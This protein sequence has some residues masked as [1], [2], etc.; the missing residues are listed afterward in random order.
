MLK[1]CKPDTDTVLAGCMILHHYNTAQTGSAPDLPRLQKAIS[2]VPARS[3]SPDLLFIGPERLGSEGDAIR[4]IVCDFCF[5]VLDLFK[6]VSYLSSLLCH[7]HIQ[8]LLRC[9]PAESL[10]L[11]ET[12]DETM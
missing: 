7:I 12:D 1:H 10:W 9:G 3:S 4:L 8:D 5:L 6:A 2:Q 11:G